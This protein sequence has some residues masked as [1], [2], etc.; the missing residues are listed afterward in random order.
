MPFPAS[1]PSTT[2]A[3][4]GK[5]LGSPSDHE[6]GQAL[7]WVSQK[8]GTPVSDVTLLSSQLSPVLSLC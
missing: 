8:S 5:G 1:F 6:E 4:G 2:A 7:P 3:L